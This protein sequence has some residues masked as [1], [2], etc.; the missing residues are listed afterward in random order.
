MLTRDLLA[1]VRIPA[2]PRS[3]LI[4]LWMHVMM[5]VLTALHIFCIFVGVITVVQLST[6]N[7]DDFVIWL[8]A[9]VGLSM[10]LSAA[11][12][13]GCIGIWFRWNWGVNFTIIAAVGLAVSL[14]LIL[15]VA[16]TI[17]K[18]WQG[19]YFILPFTLL[20]ISFTIR[21][22]LMRREWNHGT[23]LQKDEPGEH[24]YRK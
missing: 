15:V 24:E 5:G 23:L 1:S 22:F 12:I 16:A 21:L 8:V 3:S 6:V 19:L 20:H 14:I 11:N 7:P 13:V 2:P 10:A 4:P 18:F 9:F 17:K